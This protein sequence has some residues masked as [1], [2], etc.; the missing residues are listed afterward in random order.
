VAK[1]AEKPF[2]VKLKQQNVTVHGTSF[3]IE[4]YQE[5]AYNIVT[6]L[7]GSV[8]LESM[9]RNGEKISDL[10]L[11]PGQKAYFDNSAE[12]V[13]VEEV[14][15]SLSNTWIK[16]EYK[17]KDEP[18]ALIVKRL[19]NYYDVQIYLDDKRLEN[20]KYTGTFSLNQSIREV[21]CIINH[22]NRFLYQQTGNEIHIKSK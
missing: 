3:N 19:E 9:S 6:L 2:V 20:I 21:L 5:E 4:A 1:D 15:A 14:D 7:S 11:K 16:G 12:K 22:E 8:S 17:F 18:L 10:V 13:S